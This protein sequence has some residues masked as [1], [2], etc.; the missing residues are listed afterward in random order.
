MI[1][2][3]PPW[4]AIIRI[5][6]AFGIVI[7]IAVVGVINAIGNF[8]I[9]LGLGIGLAAVVTGVLFLLLLVAQWLEPNNLG[10]R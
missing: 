9:A 1:K 8:L 2:K 7:V 4:W 3:D 6:L 5:V 10:R